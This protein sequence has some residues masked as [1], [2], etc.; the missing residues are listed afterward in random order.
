MDKLIANQLEIYFEDYKE[1][2]IWIL[3]IFFL[4]TIII[5]F[6]SN[7]ILSK[8]IEKFKNDLKMI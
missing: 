5:Q 1:N 8:K 3:S 6:I 4:L 2:M 7:L